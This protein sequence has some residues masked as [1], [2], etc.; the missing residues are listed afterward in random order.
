[1]MRRRLKE[2]LQ[3]FRRDED[4]SMIVLTM[5]LLFGMIV[6]GG[7]AVDLIRAENTRV[8]LQSTLDR[9]I[10]AATRLDVCLV[11]ASDA[12]ALVESYLD[13]TGFDSSS[14][15]IRVNPGTSS[16]EIEADANLTMNTI[17]MSFL[18]VPT[19]PVV[20]S[21]AAEQSIGNVEI[22]L[23]LDVSYSMRRNLASGGTTKIDALRPAAREFI[24][25]VLAQSNGTNATSIN[26]VQYGGY[27][28]PG[29]EMF[30][31]LNGVRLPRPPLADT[32]RA[33]PAGDP[34]WPDNSSCMELSASDYTSLSLPASGATQ[35]PIFSMYRFSDPALQGWGWCPHDRSSIIYASNSE[36]D[37]H[38]AIDNIEL[39]PGT[40]TNVGMKWGAALLDPSARSAF[41]DLSTRGEIA[42]LFADRP[43]AHVPGQ[44]QKFIVL[45]TDGN[46]TGQVRPTNIF[47][48]DNLVQNLAS[49]PGGLSR[50][51]RN[52]QSNSNARRT[53]DQMC[54]VA[55]DEDIII[56]TIAFNTN[57]EG[58]QQMFDCATS[59]SHFFN[60]EDDISDAFNT[61]ASQ[62]SA[63]RL[64]N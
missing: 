45:M 28:N 5:F 11:S 23:V 12:Q 35:L 9:G 58:Q 49:Q 30:D 33:E 39:Y 52:S 64:T 34:L 56:F 10:L 18:G 17:F 31:I 2:T 38:T 41:A 54:Q 19:L 21:S 4:G 42:P 63:L 14:A 60:V 26:L 13:L 32:S 57:A 48:E 36:S 22:S 43:L 3:A 61:I 16:C 44:N 25:D 24:T 59:P 37:L 8:R 46:I 6:V 62:I 20:I 55:K 51:R 15:N 50:N 40:G 27:V 29:R 7:S 53:F 47:N 1:M